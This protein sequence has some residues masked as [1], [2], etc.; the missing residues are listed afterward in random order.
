MTSNEREALDRHITGNYGEDQYKH[1][2]YKCLFCD[3]EA[4]SADAAI[5]AGWI[6]SFYNGE[7]EIDVAV[8]PECFSRHL[9][10]GSNGMP[11]LKP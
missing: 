6:P 2:F 3:A 9:R 4:A 1:D 7:K 11:E 5:D 10:I 8:C